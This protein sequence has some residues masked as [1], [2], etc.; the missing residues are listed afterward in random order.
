VGGYLVL[1][2]ILYD[3]VDAVINAYQP[4]FDEFDVIQRAEWVR[5]EARK[6]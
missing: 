4:W 3:Q 1:S 5:I 2:G 6:I